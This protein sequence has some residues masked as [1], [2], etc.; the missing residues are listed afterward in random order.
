LFVALGKLLTRHW[1]IVLAAWAIVLATMLLLAPPTSSVRSQDDSGFLPESV[2]S[3]QAIDTIR[4]HFD[5]PPAMSIAAVVMERPE[6]LTGAPPTATQPAQSDSDWGYIARVTGRLQQRAP[7]SHWALMSPADPR[8]SYLRKNLIAADDRAA[9]IRVDLP[10]GFAS[11]EA[12]EAVAWIQRMTAEVGPPPGLKVAVTGSASYGRDSNTA[13]ETS[14]HRTTWVCIIAVILILLITYR[15]LPA[16]AISLVTVS[17]AVVVAISIV[18]IGGALGWSISILVEVFTI[19]VGY[20]A[21]VDFSLFFL[22]RYHEELARHVGADTRLGRRN[23]L[24]RALVGAGPVIVAAAAT[25]AAGLSLMYFA[26]FRVFHSAGPAVAISIILSCLAS[27]TL[28]PV[29]AYL[30][31]SHAFWPRRMTAPPNVTD[32]P[33]GFWDR[34]AAFAVRRRVHILILGLVALIPLAGYGWRQEKVY[35]TLAD[36][37]QTDQSAQ[38]ARIFERH[39]PVGEMSPIQILVQMDRPLGEADW[40]AVAMAVDRKLQSMAQVEQVRSLAHPL[41]P[42]GIEI[43]PRQVALLAA[44]EPT[45]APAPGGPP[46]M[47]SQ[48]GNLLVGSLEWKT[49]KKQF[50]E[51]VLPR[52]V[53]RGREAALWE[54]ALAQRPYTNQ[55]L[56]SLAPLAQAV[57]EAIQEVPQAATA[58]P[59]VLMAGDTATMNDLRQVTNHDFWFVGALAVMAI[60]LIVTLLIRDLPVA[61][62]VMLSTILTYGAALGLTSWLFHL[63]LGTVGLDWKVDFS[64]FVILVAVGQDYNLFLLT[65][66]MEN[67]RALP[68][69]PAVQAAVARTGSII[70]YCGLIMAV[71]L[72]SLASSPLRLLQEL[73]TAFIIGLLI[74]TFVVRPLMVPAFI[75]VFKRLNRAPPARSKASGPD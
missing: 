26:K 39:F 33:G 45:T 36:L 44:Q 55:A 19:V 63:A 31:G 47:L 24:I 40:A 28:T 3:R 57:R 12:S 58:S 17:V 27:L 41:G 21:G 62:F 7:Q 54:V 22:S 1:V 71:T 35:D 56:D 15:A 67:R 29:L 5:K 61:L 43:P 30:A 38:G 6:G 70:S 59:R 73:G 25:V 65:R 69:Q 11:H 34:V 52:Y 64:L 68:L 23:A 32:S 37:P 72:G 42:K 51:E 2:P 10:G 66:V 53:G 46:S 14:L 18:A 60:I 75:L 74:D 50:Q 9:V 16:A 48:V 13:A 4:S 49:A 8:Q 20:G